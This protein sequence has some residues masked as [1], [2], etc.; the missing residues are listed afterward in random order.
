MHIPPIS[1]IKSQEIQNMLIKVM[2][3][4]GETNQVVSKQTSNS[5]KILSVSAIISAEH[6]GS[7]LLE[8]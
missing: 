4:R 3:G 1:E 6:N 5:V 7:T 8:T 2:N